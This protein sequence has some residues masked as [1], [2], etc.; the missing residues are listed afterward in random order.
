MTLSK[1]QIAEVLFTPT[2]DGKARCAIC[3]RSYAPGN[4]YTN[5]LSHARTHEGY[6]DIAEEMFISQEAHK[7]EGAAKDSPTSSDAKQP[8]TTTTTT[9]TTTATAAAAPAPRPRGRPPGSKNKT[10]I[11]GD[12]TEKSKK[13]KHEH[14]A[15][16]GEATPEAKTAGTALPA[17]AQIAALRKELQSFQGAMLVAVSAIQADVQALHQ[18]VERLQT[19]VNE[20]RNNDRRAKNRRVLDTAKNDNVPLRKLVRVN[21]TLGDGI[22]GGQQFQVPSVAVGDAFPSPPFPTTVGDVE[23]MQRQ[24]IH[25]LAVLM[26]NDFGIEAG[27]NLAAC[28]NKVRAALADGI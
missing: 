10:S 6:E 16:N 4:G 26:N 22:S 11:S 8:V 17:K 18:R 12:A 7:T 20:L 14:V 27:D 9:A 23:T 3:G 28:R 21:K 2:E 1:R 25:E 13:R 24:R 19:D 15:T 5:R